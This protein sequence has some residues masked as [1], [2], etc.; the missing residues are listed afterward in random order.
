MVQIRMPEDSR[1][2]LECPEQTGITQYFGAK[3]NCSVLLP[4][5]YISDG[6]GWLNTGNALKF[7]TQSH[8][9]YKI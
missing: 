8:L 6:T 5:R 7:F 1:N 2:G 3:R 4:V 9:T